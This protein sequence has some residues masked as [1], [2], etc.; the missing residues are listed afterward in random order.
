MSQSQRFTTM[1]SK[2]HSEE[3][4][5]KIDEMASSAFLAL[6]CLL[7]CEDDSCIRCSSDVYEE[8]SGFALIR[9]PSVHIQKK[10]SFTFGRVFASFP[11]L[12]FQ[13]VV[14][15]APR[16]QQTISNS[17]IPPFIF[18]FFFVIQTTSILNTFLNFRC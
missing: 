11:L 13:E 3:V 12:P 4:I 2:S 8:I 16:C 10:S 18:S 17:T 5:S 6:V 7:W 14:K 15:E 9:V 1:L